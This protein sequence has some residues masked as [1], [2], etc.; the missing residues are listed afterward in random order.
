M[1]NVKEWGNQSQKNEIFMDPIF[2]TDE[3]IDLLKV[4][5]RTI[6]NWRDEG[7]IEF[8]AIK[9]KF[10]YRLSAITKMLDRNAVNTSPVK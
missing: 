10:Y 2:N 9:G 5:R 8:S 1:A 6:Q 7:I 4:S 3:L